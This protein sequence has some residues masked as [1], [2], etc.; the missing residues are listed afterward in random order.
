MTLTSIFLLAVLALA[1][2]GA[3]RVVKRFRA[4]D[5]SLS[6]WQRLLA[7]AMGSA[8]VLWNGALAV[9]GGIM[10]YSVIAAEALN[11]P[12]VGTFI[13]SNLN[14]KYVGLAVMLIG[15]VGALARMRTLWS[16]WRA[17]GVD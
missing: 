14:P 2:Y 9:G 12:E 13:Q 4:T 5:P 6:L 11:A 3:Y 17:Q 1:A 16:A 8:S 10:S 15:A 7:T